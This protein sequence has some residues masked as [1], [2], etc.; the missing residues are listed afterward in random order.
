M[1]NCSSEPSP[2][3]RRGAPPE[4]ASGYVDLGHE[5]DGASQKKALQASNQP[6]FGQPIAEPHASPDLAMTGKPDGNLYNSLPPCEVAPE[7]KA[8]HPKYGGPEYGLDV[9]SKLFRVVQELYLEGK[10]RPEKQ[11]LPLTLIKREPSAIKVAQYAGFMPDV[12]DM[13]RLTA[14]PNG[15]FKKKLT[16]DQYSTLLLYIEAMLGGVP[17]S[18]VGLI[19]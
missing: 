17:D 13:D 3:G 2:K 15:R 4:A 1:G 12:T 9:L 8:L 19:Y 5:W 11:H 6:G 16:R 18:T 7:I 14:A 10:L